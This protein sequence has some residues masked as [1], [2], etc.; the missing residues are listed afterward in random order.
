MQVTLFYIVRHDEIMRPVSNVVITC[1]TYFCVVTV[2][3]NLYSQAC[4]RYV[5]VGLYRR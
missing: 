1:L 2:N 5:C 3:K 4:Y